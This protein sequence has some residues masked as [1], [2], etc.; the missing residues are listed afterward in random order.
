MDPQHIPIIKKIIKNI[1]L[2]SAE[3]IVEKALN[4]S[5]SNDIAELIKNKFGTDILTSNFI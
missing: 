4:M 3:Q 2:K 1:T 5:V